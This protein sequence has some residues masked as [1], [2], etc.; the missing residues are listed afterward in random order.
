MLTFPPQ[1]IAEEVNT[2]EPRPVN[3]PAMPGRAWRTAL[4]GISRLAFGIP[5]GTTIELPVESVL[6]AL[7][8]GAGRPQ[9]LS[10]DLD[11]EEDR[12]AIELP[13]DSPSRPS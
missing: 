6:S 11:A 8:G 3:N 1:H 4:A 7:G 9:L 12:S 5:E 13:W 2:G 10:G